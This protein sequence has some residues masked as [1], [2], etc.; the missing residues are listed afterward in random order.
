M[1]TPLSLAEQHRR[2]QAK[3]KEALERYLLR[4]YLSM[5]GPRDTRQLADQWIALVLPQILAYRARS[6]GLARVTYSR[7]RELALG[8]GAGY[9]EP[10]PDDID[11]A[12][13][14]SSLIATGLA[15]LLER[16]GKGEPFAEAIVSASKEA[17]GA[18]VRHALN[19][20]RSYYERAVRNDVGALGWYRVTR[21]GCCSFCAVLASRGAIYK[22][23][24]FDDSDPRF[25]GAEG[26]EKVH[27]H[28][29]CGL[30]A[31]WK[32]GEAVPDLS[33]DF[34]KLWYDSIKANERDVATGRAQYVGQRFSGKDALNAFRRAYE[35]AYPT[36]G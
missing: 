2:S 33:R 10:E 1:A 29:V 13:V 23:D 20:G 31:I 22:A 4:T 18:G 8:A 35:V 6:A 21:P 5:L 9:F 16:V 26:E 27:D 25:E 30:Q 3:L 17:S 28:C 15:S 34:E 14:T 11:E 19:G 32:P 12:T 24:S 7:S 36:D